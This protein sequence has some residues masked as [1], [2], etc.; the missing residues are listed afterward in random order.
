M[1]ATYAGGVDRQML[2]RLRAGSGENGPELAQG[3]VF[4]AKA[5]QRAGNPTGHTDLAC[6]VFGET[7]A[8]VAA[9]VADEAMET[10]ATN[11]TQP[12]YELWRH[13]IR[14]RFADSGV[15]EA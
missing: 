1:A 4:A 8:D 2:E 11:G 15:L 9:R 6:Q 3:A 7:S 10:S 12:V 5:R 14:S 13:R